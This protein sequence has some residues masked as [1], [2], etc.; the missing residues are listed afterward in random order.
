MLGRLSLLFLSV[1][2]LSA[3][4]LVACG[5]DDDDG[6]GAI[7]TATVPAANPTTPPAAATAPAGSVAVAMVDFGYQPATIPARAGQR[8]QLFVTNRGQA[9]HTF[10]IDG[11]TDSGG[12]PA[13]ESKLV[14][15]TPAQ[16]GTLSFYCTI[17]GRNT[18]S[19]ELN[20]TAQ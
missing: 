19:G 9:P 20:V 5:G 3:L 7:V 12:M 14:E 13:G 11:V 10:T 16:A 2:A 4:A 17:H 18:M 1:I 6:G 15:F 8:I